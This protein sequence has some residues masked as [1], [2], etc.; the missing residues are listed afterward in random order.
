MSH[1][2]TKI[3]NLSV[4]ACVQFKLYLPYIA[5][6]MILFMVCSGHAFADD[7]LSGASESVASTF[8]EGSSFEKYLYLGEAVLGGFTYMKTKNIM[9]LAGVP[10]LMIFTHLFFGAVSS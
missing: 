6:I 5:V 2:M 8:G 9:V 7:Y 10:V 4:N 3:N 1:V